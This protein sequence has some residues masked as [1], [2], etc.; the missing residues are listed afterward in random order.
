MHSGLQSGFVRKAFAI[1]NKLSV[2]V[3]LLPEDFQQPN[4]AEWGGCRP[5]APTAPSPEGCAGSTGPDQ[6]GE[7]KKAPGHVL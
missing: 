1:R 7:G 3:S 2:E 6:K 4:G 5:G